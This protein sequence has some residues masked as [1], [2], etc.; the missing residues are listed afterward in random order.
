MYR[1]TDVVKHLLIINILLAAAT[2]M[3]PHW[4]EFLALYY[5]Q[6]DKFHPVQV[7]SH[8]F[9]HAGVMHLFFNMYALFMFGPP[10]ETLYGPK[11]F[12]FYYLFCAF[13]AALLHSLYN[14]YDFSQLQAAIDAFRSAPS[15]DTYW[16]FFN[17]VN[18]NVLTESGKSSVEAASQALL[19]GDMQYAG[20]STQL[21]ETI[22]ERKMDVPAVGASGAIYGLLLAFGM[23]FPNAELMLI[24]LPIPIKAKYFIPLLMAAEFYFGTQNFAWDNIA[25]FAHLGGALSGFL[26]ILYWRKTGHRLY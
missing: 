26:L 23:Q 19:Q 8:F 24:F 4:T 14:W 10:I 12:L 20:Q 7:V 17:Q 1:I 9:M 13:G 16:E 15:Y 6:S 11:R 25:H 2:W 3:F 22:L 21:M 18:M 5:P